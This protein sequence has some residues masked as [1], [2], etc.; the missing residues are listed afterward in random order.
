MK[1]T[2]FKILVVFIFMLSACSEKKQEIN[3]TNNTDF[4]RNDELV[5]L[6][7]ENIVSFSENKKENLL[8]IFIMGTDTLTSQLV[9]E[10]QDGKTDEILVELSFKPGETKTINYQFINSVD[11]PEFKSKTNI[12]L[13]TINDPKKELT[14]AIRVQT[15][16]TKVM[17][18]KLQMEGPAWENDKVGFRNYFD[19]RNGMDIYGKTVSAMV[20]DT[21][22]LNSNY[23]ELSD[24]GMDILKVGNS[25]GSGSIAIKKKDTLYRIGDNGHGSYN[26]LYEGPLKSK[27]RFSFNDYELDGTTTPVLQDI[28]IEAGKYAFKST[29]TVPDPGENSN[30]VAG[31][32]NKHSDTIYNMTIGKNHQLAITHDRQAEDGS[33]LAIGLLTEDQYYKAQSQTPD[34]GEGITETYYVSFNPNDQNEIVFYLYAFWERRNS[35]FNDLNKIKKIIEGDV[36]MIENP[37]LVKY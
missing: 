30:L 13:A 16:D 28:S 9:D 7:P 8:P 11:Y 3:L 36:S 12:H 4:E 33:M 2:F 23:H 24:W 35:D 1:N 29:V 20:L 25:L 10:D 32:V 14:E 34:E 27:Y 19:L 31:I 18:K 17:Q 37:I 5:V 15:A 26:L 22:G 6:K 21:V